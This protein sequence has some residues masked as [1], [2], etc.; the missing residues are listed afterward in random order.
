MTLQRPAYLQARQH[1][2]VSAKLAAGLGVAQPPR[3]SLKDDRFTLLMANGD[4]HPT[5][6]ASLTVDVI[7]VGGNANASKIYYEGDYDS[8]DAVAPVCWS[9]NGVAPSERAGTPQ[10]ENCATCQWAVWGSKISNMGSKVQ[11]CAT[12]KKIAVI[13]AGAGDTVFLLQIPPNSLKPWRNYIAHLQNLDGTEA[14]EVITRV[15]MENKTLGFEPVDFL[16]ENLLGYVDKVI[17]SDEPAIVCGER[18]RPRQ[19]ALP[20][21]VTAETRQISQRPEAREEVS[22]PAKMAAA[23][24]TFGPATPARDTP[25][26][27][28]ARIK[29]LEA[30]LA[31]LS[32]G[33]GTVAAEPAPTEPVRRRRA[34]ARPNET[35]VGAGPVPAGAFL[36]PGSPEIAKS[37]PT[38]GVTAAPPPPPA[39]VQAAL[40]KAFGFGAG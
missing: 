7:V 11:A 2:E 25:D 22:A 10:S 14:T 29:A 18:D 35:V 38:F 40:D 12:Y 26:E 8:A 32:G 33:Q 5:I 9:D 1:T 24:A 30:Q 4:K 31:K 21:P 36:A 37:Q 15:S 16:P 23:I 3:L 27:G 34:A 39:G 20:A 6:A 13:V 19:G 28:A 17:G